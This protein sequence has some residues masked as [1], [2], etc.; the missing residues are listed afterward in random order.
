M[1]SVKT[2]RL[3]R[4]PAR[5]PVRVALLIVA[6][7]ALVGLTGSAVM[8]ALATGW[9]VVL[10]VAA[11]LATFWVLT[12]RAWTI[13]TYCNTTGVVVRGLFSTRIATW[14]SVERVDDVDGRVRMTLRDGQ[15]IDTHVTRHGLDL[16]GRAEAFDIAKLALQHFGEQS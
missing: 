8:A 9:L 1:G 13:G 2:E 6:T 11:V 15:R 7:L 14:E 10:P 16:A 3:T 12:L 5:G 4:I